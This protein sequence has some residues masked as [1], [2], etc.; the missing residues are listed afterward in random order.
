MPAHRD[1]IYRV[2]DA[3][4][5]ELRVGQASAELARLYRQMRAHCCAF[6]S[7]CGTQAGAGEDD[8]RHQARLAQELKLRGLPFLTGVGQD[9]LGRW[10]AEPGFLVPRL[11]LE[12]AK[13]MGRRYS[14]DAIVW[15]GA[16][17]VPRLELLR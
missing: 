5:F 4:A 16:D 9:A 10:P 1:A 14:R 6:L 17:T 2:H 3:P 11:S 12:A 15:C 13:Q 8:A 7:A